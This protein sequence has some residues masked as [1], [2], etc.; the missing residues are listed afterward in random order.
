MPDTGDNKDYA[1]AKDALTKHFEPAKN[2]IY[3]IYNFRQAKQG[4]DETIDQ[5]HTRL[6]TLAQHCDFHNTDFE[7]KMQLV[8]NGTSSRLR[9]K[10]L[11]DPSY[12]LEDMLIDRRKT[13]VSSAQASGMK[14]TFQALQIKDVSTRNSCY[15]CGFSFP[16]KG[17]PCP[18]RQAICSN[19]GVKGHFAKVCRKPKSAPQKKQLPWTPSQDQTPRIS[20]DK[21]EYRKSHKA[22]QITYS[23]A[24]ES[25]SSDAEYAYALDKERTH[26][27]HKTF[28]RLNDSN[29][30]FLID[31]GAT[32]DVI[33]N[34]TFQSLKKKVRLEPT[35]TKIFIYGSSTPLKLHGC[36]Q[37]SIESKSRFTVSTFYVVDGPG[38]N[39]LS[40]KTAQDLALIQLVNTVKGI[41]VTKEPP[42]A[43][44]QDVA[45]VNNSGKE[46]DIPFSE[47][48]V[49]DKLLEKHKNVFIGEGK[50]KGQ[51]AKLHIRE[52]ITPVLQPQRRVPY[53]M[54]KAVSKELKKLIA[55]DIIEPV[56]DQP[57]P[58]ISP[59]VCV[60]KKDGGTRICVDM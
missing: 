9:R 19:C 4:A 2:P 25:S 27:T 58:W 5:F 1:K 53:H 57:T 54:R 30:K 34:P 47:D 38:G 55:Q 29:V 46:A 13:E 7:I 21:N 14:E 20:Y 51:M 28:L 6:R 45:T 42:Q 3:E 41:N 49:I 17:K 60:P 16:H 52:D 44:K 48:E 8:C 31:T 35:K 40:A 15:K 33:D 11:R 36:F 22:R 26:S 59:I 23:P 39:L 12:K 37:A 24:N 50:I 10:A 56:K 43:N 32:V 18:A